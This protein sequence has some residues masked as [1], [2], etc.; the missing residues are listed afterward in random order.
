[1]IF[2]SINGLKWIDYMLEI[3]DLFGKGNTYTNYIINKNQLRMQKKKKK[4]RMN[5][6]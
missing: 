5:I 6:T 2:E 1:M 4:K 3:M